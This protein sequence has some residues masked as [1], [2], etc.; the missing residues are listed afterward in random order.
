MPVFRS[1]RSCWLLLASLAVLVFGA[2]DASA[3]DI[4]AGVYHTCALDDNGVSCWGDN[5]SGQ[6]TVPAGLANPSAIG[7]GWSYT[8]ALDDNGVSCWGDT[9][10]GSRADDPS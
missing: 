9:F 8:C 6:T 2:M 3:Y 7:A 5:V 1:P 10:N 4:A